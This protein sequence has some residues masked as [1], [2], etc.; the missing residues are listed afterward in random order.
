MRVMPS[1]SFAR[2]VAGVLLGAVATAQAPSPWAEL[3]VPG[4]V[5]ATALSSQGK[6]V[7]FRDAGVLHAWSAVTRTFTTAPITGSASLRLNN[8]CILVQDGPVWTAY[9][10]YTGQFA[11]LPV[12][13]SATLVNVPGAVN[14]SLLAVADGGTLHVFSAFT[15]TWLARP[16]SPS[17]TAAVQRHAVVLHDGSTLGGCDAYTLQWTDLAN[18]PPVTT[19]SA[20][21]TAGFAIGS[22]RVHAFSATRRTWSSTTLPPGA[23]FVRADDWGVFHAGNRALGWSAVRASFATLDD[24]LT[25]TLSTQDLFCLFDTAAGPRAF[26]APTGEWST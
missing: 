11:P 2:R 13:A 8:D 10:A 16:I 25:S 14:D 3:H 7:A 21:G 6:V 24:T 1:R 22:G 12:G 26:S 15:G 19:L 5:A 18:V 20:D 17:W 4:G 9:A 23:A